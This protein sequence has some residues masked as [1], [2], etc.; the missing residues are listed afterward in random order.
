MARIAEEVINK[1]KSDISLVR[2]AE[3]QGF[4]LVK[5]GKDYAVC[6]P[7]HEEKTPS[8]IISPESNLFNCFGCGAGGSV[9]DWVMKTQSVSFR[10]AC[11]MLQKDL[12]V[13][14]ENSTSARIKNTKTKLAAPLSADADSQTA[15]RQV[16]DFYH[17][18]FKQSPEA[19]DYLRQRGLESAELIEH[20][21]LGFANRTLGYHLPEKNRKAGKELRGK[22]QEIGILRESGHEHFNG[23]LVVPV[24]DENEVI[25]EVYGRKLLDNLRKGTPKHTYLPGPHDGVFNEKALKNQ[26]EIILCESLIDA[27]TFWVHGFRNVT[28]SYGTQGF[29][30][31][32]LAAF[33]RHGIK[34][35]LIAY[36]RD[37]P[38]NTAADKHAAMMQA[39]GIDCFRILF[40]QG[41]DANSY[42]LQ[43]T[44]ARK[45]LELV[46][47]KAEWLGN[48]KPP[49]ITTEMA[50]EVTEEHSHSAFI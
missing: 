6:C 12:G 44:P 37:D 33:K 10:F 11:E 45:S 3:S 8:C 28:A 20:F 50:V 21:K 15:L 49:E 39:E 23:S 48:G 18:T 25:T 24:F 42:A 36:D 47:R 34:R 22:L 9:I 30:A 29:T 41:M 17:D 38:G 40:P 5:Q 1:I 14:A 32:H 4:K 46:I 43:V 26:S 13:I 19:Q 7:F 31:S 35:V 2:L 27:M 16:I